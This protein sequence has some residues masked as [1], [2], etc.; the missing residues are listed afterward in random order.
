[1]YVK[2]DGS[3]N[4]NNFTLKNCVYLNLCCVVDIQYI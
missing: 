3:E 4:I 2:I 1:M